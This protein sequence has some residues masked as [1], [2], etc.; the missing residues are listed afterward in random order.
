M[1]INSAS[2]NRLID[3]PVNFAP[4]EEENQHSLINRISDFV[5]AVFYYIWTGIEKIF[6]FFT[7]KRMVVVPPENSPIS[8]S[9]T[10]ENQ[11]QP[12]TA[13][14]LE[15]NAIETPKLPSIAECI[16][17][18]DRANFEKNL[19]EIAKQ[20]NKRD[21]LG[22][23]LR[24]I[25]QRGK[26]L[27]FVE[28]LKNHGVDFAWQDSWGNTALIWA[29]ANAKNTAAIEIIRQS[30]G[31]GINIQDDW[32]HENTALHLAIAKGYKTVSADGEPLNHSNFE[33]VKAL[34]QAGA[35][36]NLYNARNQTPLHLACLRRDLEMVK[37]LVENGAQL[38]AMNIFNETPL[39]QLT[40][41]YRAAYL[42]IERAA[43]PFLLD[44]DDFNKNTESILEFL[45]AAK[46]KQTSNG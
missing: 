13:L 21:L 14:G 9:V 19:T 28:I 36:V 46:V 27:E 37:Y 4:V 5:K 38:H 11:L 31:Q 10:N 41:T 35:D 43:K 20:E 17:Q 44:S 25:A 2:S 7:L 22:I 30:Q 16:E 3:F 1:T 26:S 32:G 8:V 39:Q 18:Q 24:K 42:E 12:G 40:K 29:I 23:A 6:N 33:V 15:K 34:I 45:N